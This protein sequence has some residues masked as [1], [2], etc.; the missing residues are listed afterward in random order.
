MLEG[1]YNLRG[2]LVST[3]ARSVTAHIRALAEP[4]TQAW[5]PRDAEVRGQHMAHTRAK[6]MRATD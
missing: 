4:H 3:F 1:G 6:Q 5:D 2:R